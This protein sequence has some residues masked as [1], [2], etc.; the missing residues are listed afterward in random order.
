MKSINRLRKGKTEKRSCGKRAVRNGE[1][2]VSEGAKG[3]KEGE[4]RN[5]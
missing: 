2:R 4:W 5:S 3:R 1:G